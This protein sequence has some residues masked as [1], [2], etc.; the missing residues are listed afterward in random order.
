MRAA[1]I[2]LLLCAVAHATPSDDLDQAKIAYRN[3]QYSAALPLFNS[4]LYPDRKLADVNETADA[5]LALGVCRYETGDLRGA[6]RE[7]EAALISNSN[8]RLDPLIVTDPTAL[9][10]FNETRLNFQDQIRAEAER[11]RRI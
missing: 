8:V 9:A 6:K 11:K 1:L 2:I 5:Y 10:A 4:L 7:F 3:G